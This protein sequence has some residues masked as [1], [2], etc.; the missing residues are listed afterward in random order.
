MSMFVSTTYYSTRETRKRE[1][2]EMAITIVA[3]TLG[4]CVAYFGWILIAAST[5]K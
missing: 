4:C 2:A 3:G 5:C 1:R